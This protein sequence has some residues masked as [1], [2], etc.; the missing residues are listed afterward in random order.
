MRFIL[1]ILWF[2]LAATA[3]NAEYALAMH[4]TPKY[5]PN[6][7]HF[8]Y[9]NPAVPQGGTL[10][11][12]VVG[13][14]D[15]VNPFSLR[16]RGAFG[17]N[18][19]S[20]QLYLYDTLLARSQDE[21]FTLYGLIAEDV[22]T[23]P[24][25][26]RVTF[27]LNPAARF[28]DGQPITS[29]DV[30][31]SWE[32]LRQQGRPNHRNYYNKVARIDVPDAQH[33]TFWFK[34]DAAGRI[35][36]EMPLI[37]GL[38][39]VLPRHIWETRDITAPSLE[40]LVGSG[41][42]RIKQLDPGRSIVWERVPDYWARNIP[43]QRGLYNFDAV[44]VDYYR[45][46]QV[47]LQAFKAGHYD[48]RRETDPA[49][50]ATAYNGNAQ[51]AGHY[52]LLTLPHGRVE[53]VRA[54]VFN[55]RRPLF[56]DKVL[57]QAIAAALDDAWLNRVLFYGELRRTRSYFPNSPLAAQGLPDAATQALLAP[58]RAQLPPALFTTDLDAPETLDF[59][60]RLRHAA[61]SLSAAGYTV[62]DGALYSPSGQAV[63][64]TLLLNEPTEQKVAAQLARS[65]Q[66]LGISLRIQMVESAQFQARQT[67]FDYDMMLVRWVNSLSPGNEQ[68]MYWGAAAA[69]QSGTRNYAGIAEPV[70]DALIPRII[71]APSRA[72]LI[73]AVQTLDRVLRF[74]VYSVPLF[75]DPADH[76]ALSQTIA[77]PASLPT[78]GLVLESL[79]RAP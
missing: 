19:A 52:R 41:P 47:A 72:E 18:P 45:D 76:Y 25:R 37:I 34:P 20:G 6:F 62:Q 79:W 21:P 32:R 42:Y 40:P 31:F 66:Q 10:R 61:Q 50:W 27:R 64:F 5:P 17:A 67:N 48:L 71:A 29:A 39:P 53:G 12:G 2:C 13:A 43:S 46:E 26:D 4:G 14:Y 77:M 9:V 24:E 51:E 38:M 59:V 49:R 78:N 11:L 74:G 16:G 8:A 22:Q 7:Q 36:R 58:W 3:A 57:R 33:I 60:T 1:M 30:A 56:Q 63:A 70:I 15:S 55:L 68:T 35:D 44:Q 69:A 54:F 75:Y 28:H 65:L 73:S 23:P